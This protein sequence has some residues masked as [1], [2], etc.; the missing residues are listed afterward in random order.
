MLFVCDVDGTIAGT[1]DWT[2]EEVRETLARMCKEQL[3]LS[4]SLEGVCSGKALMQLP[5]V[6][7]YRQAHED[8]WRALIHQYRSSI[9]GM[10]DAR[11]MPKA[12]SGMQQLAQVGAVRYYTIR[13]SDTDAQLNQSIQ[14]TTRAWLAENK[15]PYPDDVVFCQSFIHK[16]A[17]VARE[18]EEQIAF[19]DDCWQELLEAYT[20]I[21]AGEYPKIAH[22]AE[23][24]KRR[25]VIVAFGASEIAARHGDLRVVP[26]PSWENAGN[27]LHSFE[28]YPV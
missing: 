18:E 2:Q 7:S 16:L 10:R 20:L 8:R 19:I 9:E 24:L 26:L 28:V 22:I 15:F 6:L 14:E 13:K 25:L 11:P 17:S 5:E 21:A 1:L 12:V 23:D 4:F 27:L 3:G